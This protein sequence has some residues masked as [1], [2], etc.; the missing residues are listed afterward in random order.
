MEDAITSM[1]W[2]PNNPCLLAVGLA[3]VEKT[4]Q[5]IKIYNVSSGKAVNMEGLNGGNSES[6]TVTS[7]AVSQSG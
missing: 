7:V 4:R 3:N 6:G 2:V 5:L 1:C